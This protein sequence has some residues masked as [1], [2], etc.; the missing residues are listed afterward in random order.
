MNRNSFVGIFFL[1]PFFLFAQIRPENGSTLNF[2]QVLLEYPSVSG[3]S[4]YKIEYS[5]NEDFTFAL[6]ATSQGT[7]TIISGLDWDKKYFWRYKAYDPKGKILFTSPVYSFSTLLAE[8]LRPEVFRV[9][10]QKAKKNQDAGLITLDYSRA[11]VD[12]SGEIVWYLPDRKEFPA[13]NKPRD[14]RLTKGNTVTFWV[15]KQVFET[16]LYGNVLWKGPNKGVVSKDTAEEYHHYFEKLPSGNYLTMGTA[17]LPVEMPDTFPE[18]LLKNNLLATVKNGKIYMK[19]EFGTLIEY[20]AKGEIVW[21]WNS[22]SYFKPADLLSL[23]Y[24]NGAPLLSTHMNAASQDINGE[25]VYAG[26]RNI[27]RIVKIE[28]KTGKVVAEWGK[29]I[30]KG[31]A[32][33]THFFSNQHDANVFPDGRIGVFNNDSITNAGVVSSAVIFSQGEKPKILWRLPCDFDGLSDGKSMKGGSVDLLPSG[34]YLICMGA[35]PR[36]L[37]VNEAK[38]LI[39]GIRTETKKKEEKAFS[40]SVQFKAHY[41]SGLYPFLSDS[42]IEKVTQKGKK[43]QIQ[44]TIYNNGTSPELYAVTLKTEKNSEIVAKKVISI[45]AQTTISESVEVF[46]PEAGI[47]HTLEITPSQHPEKKISLGIQ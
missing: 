17:Y 10:I 46:C 12:Y 38:E 18:S 20:N 40:P 47:I 9:T 8:W 16:D 44:F 31:M 21:S 1:F 19:T 4:I 2:T 41:T 27:H 35:I 33:G 11:I 22:Y 7:Q 37:E 29:N 32:P 28:K 25:Y 30:H 3:T 24:P 5:E 13:A 45:P 14:L 42:R 36:T 34:N 15:E 43:K 26:F 23:Q 39:W 6:P